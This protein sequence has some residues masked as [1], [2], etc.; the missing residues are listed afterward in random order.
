[1]NI[2]SRI[3]EDRKRYIAFYLLRGRPHE[4]LAAA[5]LNQLWTA[6]F[7]V[8][9]L[10]RSAEDIQ[11]HYDSRA[12]LDLRGMEDPVETVGAE[13]E[14]LRKTKPR[15]RSISVSNTANRPRIA[16]KSQPRALAKP[17]AA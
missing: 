7:K 17:S 8:M 5:D 13:L 3:I 9:F 4:R 10:S 16:H 6:T 12:E 2:A 1:M 14:T 15:R 11:A